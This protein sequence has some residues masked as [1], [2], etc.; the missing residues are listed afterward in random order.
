[1]WQSGD[2]RRTVLPWGNPPGTPAARFAVGD[3]VTPEPY[4]TPGTVSAVDVEACTVSVVW[5]DG[6]GGAIVYPLDASFLKKAKVNLP[7]L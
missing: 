5:S 2:G 6:D 7:W 3:I 4:D 1:M